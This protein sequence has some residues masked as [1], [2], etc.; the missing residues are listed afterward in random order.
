VLWRDPF[1]TITHLGAIWER[2]GISWAATGAL[3]AAVMAPHLSDISAGELYVSAGG[4]PE[5]RNAA[6]VAKLEP[7]EGGRLLLRP[8]P[9][10]T[11]Q[12]LTTEDQGLSLAPWPRVYADLRHTGVR[13]EEAAEHLRE[14]QR[15]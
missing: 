15:A 6:R 7:V 14:L 4:Q 13:G 2:A 3:A 9:T 12:R 8:F 10:L 1:A 5:L 11:A